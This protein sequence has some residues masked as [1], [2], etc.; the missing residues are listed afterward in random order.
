MV[1]TWLGELYHCSSLP[2]L[3]GPAWVLI[4]NIL[5]TIISGSVCQVTR[6]LTK[7]Q[8]FPAIHNNFYD[9]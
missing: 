5:H 9:H 7:D 1:G 2:V 3:P 8:K 6:E 4:S